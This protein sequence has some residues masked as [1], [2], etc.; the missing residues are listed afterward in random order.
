MRNADML[1]FIILIILSNLKAFF[2]PQFIKNLALQPV[3]KVFI[4]ILSSID[5]SVIKTKMRKNPLLAL[6]FSFLPNYLFRKQLASADTIYRH[7][8]RFS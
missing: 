2:Y 4:S 3:N 1:F 5:Y 6:Q 7:D 8:N